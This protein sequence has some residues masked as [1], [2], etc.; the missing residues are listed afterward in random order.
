MKGFTK[1]TIA[2]AATVGLAS[3]ANATITVSATPGSNPYAGPPITYDFDTS[4]TT[5]VTVPAGTTPPGPGGIVTVGTVGNLYAQPFGSTGNYYA[6]GPSTQSPGT[7]LFGLPGIVQIS[8]IWGSI[9]QYNSLTFTDAAG[10]SL[11]AAYTFTGQQIANLIPALANGNRSLA[12]TNPLVTFMFGGT[13]IGLIGG[14]QLTS[15]F[16]AFEIDNIAIT[17]GVPEPG[18]WA[19][20]LLGFGAIGFAI[21]RRKNPQELTQLA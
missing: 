10:N 7:V 6:V 3:A 1:L 14:M 17:S 19:M 8:F 5:P 20:M 12:N 15:Q 21:R 11:G 9:D 16:N 13:D 18:T 4:A 2:A